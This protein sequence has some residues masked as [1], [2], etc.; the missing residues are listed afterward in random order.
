MT[1][2]ESYLRKDYV[3]NLISEGRRADGRAFEE[4]RQLSIEKDY[5][6]DKADGSAF[7]TLGNTKVLVGVSMDIMTPYPDTPQSGVLSTGTEL[8]PIASP[9]FEIGPPRE[10]SIEIARVVDRGLRE[11]GLIDL[12]K[13]FIEEEKV[14]SVFVDIHILDHDGNLFD[15]ATVAG[16]TAL[17]NAKI[18]KIEDGKIIRG[19]W[20]GKLPTT[21]TPVSCTFAKV[22]DK[23]LLD[24]T[25]DEEYAMDSRLT[26]TTS[27]TVN[28]MQ[29]GGSGALTLEE[30][31]RAVD[32]A[33]E[34]SK[35]IRNL[36]EKA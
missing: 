17:L 8:R 23:M 15:A 5:V 36:I 35:A 26:V 30:V 6:K 27:D 28:A 25:L 24:P 18:P 12:D 3:T 19:E 1:T 14:W 31:E 29:K 22:K 21:C 10:D 16:V 20:Q 7:V 11:S 2:I 32:L 33:F 13:L 4:F 9:D 34:K